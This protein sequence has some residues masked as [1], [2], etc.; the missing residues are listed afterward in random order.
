MQWPHLSQQ[1]WHI[2]LHHTFY[3]GSCCCQ[4]LYW[5]GHLEE[6]L[7]YLQRTPRSPILMAVAAS[8]LPPPSCILL[9]SAYH[10]P[11]SERQQRCVWIL[12]KLPPTAQ[13]PSREGEVL[14]D[15]ISNFGFLLDFCVWT[16]SRQKLIHRSPES[17]ERVKKEMMC[18]RGLM[19][20]WALE[21]HRFANHTIIPSHSSSTS[22]PLV[23]VHALPGNSVKY[24][25]TWFSSKNLF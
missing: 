1:C 3:Q 10:N 8:L 5:W 11:F 19:N 13:E 20:L 23:D 2:R 9:P 12:S 18:Q 4:E 6:F 15:Q 24:I 14:W 7:A 16:G 17:Q 22:C 25:L 21:I